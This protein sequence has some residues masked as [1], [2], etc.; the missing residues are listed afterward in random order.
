MNKEQALENKI[1]LTPMQAK[2]LLGVGRNEIYELC[3]TE[4]FPAFKIKSKF[5]INKNKLQEWV[6]KQC[7]Y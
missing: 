1:L 4:G 3:K 7:G 5:Y 2:K 6:D